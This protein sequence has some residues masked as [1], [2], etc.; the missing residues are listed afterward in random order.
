MQL[1]EMPD[2][3]IT[4]E[5]MRGSFLQW[6]KI[7]MLLQRGVVIL[8]RGIVELERLTWRLLHSPVR[9]RLDWS[10]PKRFQEHVCLG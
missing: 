6:V 3:D 4:S 9:L 1:T 2:I 5:E 7:S 10:R 8:T